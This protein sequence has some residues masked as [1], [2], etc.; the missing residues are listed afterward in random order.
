[1][2]SHDPLGVHLSVGQKF[3]LAVEEAKRLRIT[4]CQLF[5]HNPRGWGFAE[6]DEPALKKFREDMK[7]AG[8]APIAA[9]CNYLINL[10]TNDTEI[11]AKSIECLKKEFLYAR[12]YGCSHFVLHVGKHKDESLEQGIKN[13]ADGINSIKAVMLQYQD[14]TLLLETVAGQ[15]SEIGRDFN[16]LGKIFAL[17]DKE[18]KEQ[19]GVCVDTCHIFA[20]GYDIRTAEKVEAT[21]AA[22]DQAFGIGKV[23]FI[24][25]NDSLKEFNSHVDRHQHI[26]EGFIGAAGFRAFLN[27]PKIKPIPKALETPV[28][29]DRGYEENLTIIRKLQA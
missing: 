20:A 6:L 13:V 22:M 26:G 24:H 3:D 21:V 9:H 12:A 14:V 7:K 18:I 29:E 19:V 16:D 15:G 1:M 2:S 25:L 28:D 4:C 10:G 17:L 5:T 8:V 27:H 23:K 11:R